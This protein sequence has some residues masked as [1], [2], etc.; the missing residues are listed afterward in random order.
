VA[1]VAIFSRG[2]GSTVWGVFTENPYL[3]AAEF[4]IDGGL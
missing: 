4:A 1:E 2:W 3:L